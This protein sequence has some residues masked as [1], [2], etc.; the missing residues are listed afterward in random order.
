MEAS[1]IANSPHIVPVIITGPMKTSYITEAEITSNN[2][3]WF[4]C[5]G[6]YISMVGILVNDIGMGTIPVAVVYYDAHLV[7]TCACT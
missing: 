2:W 5:I 1:C 6:S 4:I 3:I 7:H